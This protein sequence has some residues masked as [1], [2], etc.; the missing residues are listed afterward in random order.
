VV[1]RQQLRK[2]GSP[3]LVSKRLPALFERLCPG[4]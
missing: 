3:D 1:R 2:G 4:A